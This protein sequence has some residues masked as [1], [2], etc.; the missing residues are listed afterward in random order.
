MIM[1]WVA[2]VRENSIRNLVFSLKLVIKA[3]LTIR[4]GTA[5]I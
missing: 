4:G 2:L 1:N 5:K 3:P